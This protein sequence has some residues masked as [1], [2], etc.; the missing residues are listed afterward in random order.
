[1]FDSYRPAFSRRFN[2]TSAF[3]ECSSAPVAVTPLTMACWFNV[4]DLTS[5]HTL[6]SISDT[7]VANRF[8]LFANGFVAGDPI[9]AFTGSASAATTTSYR[10]NTW[11]HA[12]G[13]FVSKD[14]RHAYL[15]GGSKG[16]DT[17]DRTPVSPDRVT[18]GARYSTSPGAFC[19]GSIAWPAIWNAALSDADVYALAMGAHPTTIHPHNL[20]AFWD[21]TGANSEWSRGINSGAFKLVNTDSVP[22]VAPGR[23]RTRLIR[24]K[25]LSSAVSFAGSPWNYYAQTV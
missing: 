20:V 12:C 17:T 6:I 3:L 25:L 9:S 14:A 10:T 22:G 24:P 16:T 13:V 23:L 11:Q 18:I 8:G 7:G 15:D 21:W 1:M 4:G 5:P 2:G 19:I